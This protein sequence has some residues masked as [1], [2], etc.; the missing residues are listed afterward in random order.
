MLSVPPITNRPASHAIYYWWWFKTCLNN[1]LCQ[2]K[3]VPLETLEY[4]WVQPSN[5][6]ILREKK[7]LWNF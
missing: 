2:N 4:S 1:Q 7:N 6:N 5:T 3:W